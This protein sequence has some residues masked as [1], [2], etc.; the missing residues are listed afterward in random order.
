MAIKADYTKKKVG[1]YGEL[2]ESAYSECYVCIN[3]KSIRTRVVH[4][5]IEVDGT[6]EISLKRESEVK[7]WFFVHKDRDC[8]DA[9]MGILGSIPVSVPFSVRADKRDEEAYRLLKLKFDSYE[10]ILENDQ[11]I[12]G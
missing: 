7:Y 1:S 3:R 6:P 12:E 9:N 4:E 10:D 2:E 5:P 8:R 11:N